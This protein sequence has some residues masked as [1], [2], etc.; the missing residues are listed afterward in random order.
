[1]AAPARKL[2]RERRQ[3]HLALVDN[4]NCGEPI[5]AKA[6][7]VNDAKMVAK[8]LGVDIEEPVTLPRRRTA[9]K[10]TPN[11]NG[12]VKTTVLWAS[13]RAETRL[14][15]LMLAGGDIRRCKPVNHDEVVVL[16]N[17]QEKRPR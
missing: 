6:K 14:H 9:R 12:P 4:V 11:R 16:N 17:P 2:P 8:E 13:V 10:R 15:A 3:P 1:M 5:V 7:A